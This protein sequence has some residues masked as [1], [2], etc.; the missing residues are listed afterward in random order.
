ML[1]DEAARMLT[2][3]LIPFWKSLRD[4]EHGGYVGLVD[5]NLRRDMNADKGCILNS[6]I[7][8]FFS[9]SAQTLE[10]PDCLD[11]AEHAYKFL[12]DC[13]LDRQFGG[14]YWSVDYMGK[15]RDTTKHTYNQAFAVYALSEYYRVSGDREALGLARELFRLMEAKFK[16]GGGYLEAFDRELRP[17]GNEKL[18]ENGV[19]AERTMN[20]LLHVFEGCAMLCEAAGGPEVERAMAGILEI[21]ERKVYNLKL[22]RQEVFFDRDYRSL[23]DLTSYGH[24]IETSWLLDW[25]CSVLGDRAT[26]ERIGKM[27]G[28]LAE[29]VYENGFRGGSVV[30]ECENG[31]VDVT[32]I[33]WVQAEAVLGFLNRW[34]KSGDE[35]YLSA[36]REVFEHI[37]AAHE[38]FC[39]VLF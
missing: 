23:I 37:K 21:F 27:T 1:R 17:V 14:V 28:R 26:A 30:N 6:R 35:K 32:R 38:A 29:S 18:S 19:M 16:D 13:F 3:E 2:D 25:G 39:Q 4:D 11:E 22:G 33:W 31:K 36:A 10:R 12:R 7:L 9:R 15:P 24:D 8:W 5:G 34:K 20:T